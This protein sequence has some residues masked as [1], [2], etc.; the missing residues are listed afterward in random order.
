MNIPAPRELPLFDLT[1]ALLLPR[2]RL[3]LNIYETRYLSLIDDV[4][5]SDHRMMGMVQPVDSDSGRLQDIGCAGRL[6]NF[7]EVEENRYQVTLFGISRYRIK[8]ASQGQKPYIIGTLAWQEFSDDLNITAQNA[9]FDRELFFSKLTSYFEA[10]K[11][12]TNME[13]LQK[14]DN[15]SVINAMSTLCPFDATEK[16]ALLEAKNVQTRRETLEA[17][18]EFAM[19]QSNGERKQLQ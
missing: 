17:L 3:Q 14:A 15:E 10:K 8:D 12:T 1:G 6:I 9:D 18:M 16:Q 5:K 13:E 11:I 7:A 19:R 4:L 2:S